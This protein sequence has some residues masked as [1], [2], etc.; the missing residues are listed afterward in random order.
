M[1]KT[2]V[3]IALSLALS[4]CVAPK[5]ISYNRYDVS[6]L[7]IDERETVFIK[8]DTHNDVQ[9]QGMYD[10]DDIIVGAPRAVYGSDGYGGLIEGIASQRQNNAAKYDAQ[11]E[12][13]KVLLQYQEYLQQFEGG[14]LLLSVLE[15]LD[16]AY[17]FKIKQLVGEASVE[18]WILSSEPVFFMT[19]NQRELALRHGMYITSTDN[20]DHILHR[21]MVEILSA[22]SPNENAMQYWIEDNMLPI[23][24]G[25]LYAQSVQL[26][27]ADALDKYNDLESDEQTF[28]FKLGGENQFERGFLV[29][30]ECGQTTIKTLRGGFKIFPTQP[31]PEIQMTDGDVSVGSCTNFR[32]INLEQT[33]T[34]PN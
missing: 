10:Y 9:F 5:E 6:Q 13:N 34:L 21:N 31:A 11:A 25:E 18:G 3:S 17:D 14:E 8:V 23:V 16:K 20:P 24:A 28:R 12:A 4:G 22:K 15:E 33:I 19:Q 27:I 32:F 2:T 29:E 30:E 26:F 1:K 7:S